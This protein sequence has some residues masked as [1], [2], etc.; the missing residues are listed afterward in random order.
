M[1]KWEEPT[2]RHL[3]KRQRENKIIYS[4]AI[5]NPTSASQFVSRGQHIVIL[6]VVIL[7]HVYG[8]W[9]RS[10]PG[11]FAYL[12]GLSIPFFD[13]MI[14]RTFHTSS[15]YDFRSNIIHYLFS[16]VPYYYNLLKAKDCT[17]HCLSMFPS[18]YPSNSASYSLILCLLGHFSCFFVACWLFQNQFFRKILSGIASEF[19]TV[20]IQIRPD[21]LSGLIWVQTICKGYQQTT[22]VNK[23][24]S[25]TA[26]R[27][28]I[29]GALVNKLDLF[30]FYLWFIINK[31]V[32]GH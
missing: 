29:W 25:I 8:E 5:P 6:Y 16:Y 9:K 22:L 14:H 18:I 20:C 1:W 19:R 4:E 26:T 27:V 15:W 11:K 30:C 23:E 3:I 7:L 32:H 24:L 31:S 10:L 28:A 21:F 12:N 17:Q 2:L 13:C